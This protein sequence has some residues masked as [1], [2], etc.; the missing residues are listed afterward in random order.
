VT[1]K[2]AADLDQQIIV[3]PVVNTAPYF[4]GETLEDRA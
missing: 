1:I 3:N 4:Y 2:L